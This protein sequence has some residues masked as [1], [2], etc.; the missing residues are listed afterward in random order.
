MFGMSPSS[1]L[2]AKRVEGNDVISS[3]YESLCLIVSSLFES[4]F[5]HISRATVIAYFLLST[6]LTRLTIYYLLSYSFLTIKLLN[7]NKL[8]DD[9]L[10]RG[11]ALL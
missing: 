10:R 1:L 9:P 5:S 7:L 3:Y 2:K 4:V 11:Y 8:F 6:I